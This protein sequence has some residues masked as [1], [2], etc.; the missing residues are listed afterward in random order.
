MRTVSQLVYRHVPWVGLLPV[1]IAIGLA[2]L[3]LLVF[4]AW[5]SS[6]TGLQGPD[7]PYLA[8]FRWHLAARGLA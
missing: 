1:W 4:A 6:G 7:G 2:I 5:W 3:A 8:P